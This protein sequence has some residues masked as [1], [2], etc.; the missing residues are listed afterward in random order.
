MIPPPLVYV[1]DDDAAV[2]DSLLLLLESAG[3][4]AAEFD[5]AEAFLAAH[6]GDQPGCLVLDVHMPGMDGLELQNELVRRGELMPIIFLTAHGDVPKTVRAMK[7]GAVDFLTKPVN[8]KL[9]VERVQHAVELSETAHKREA[10]LKSLTQRE[11]EILKL[12]VA[13]QPNKQIARELGISYRTVEAHRSRILSK[14]GAT[15]LLE[16]ANL[17]AATQSEG[18]GRA[19]EDR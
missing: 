10:R 14:T 7:A 17:I 11:R 12:A 3:L 5:S 4:R 6:R 19:G 1:V 13:G 15:T 2:R 9:L 16:L 18:L 8:G